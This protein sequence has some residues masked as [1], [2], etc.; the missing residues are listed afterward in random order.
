MEDSEAIPSGW[1]MLTTMMLEFDSGDSVST[2]FEQSNEQTAADALAENV[3]LKN[4]DLDLECNA[5][6]AVE[7]AEVV[8]ANVAVATAHDG[9]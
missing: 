9:Q 5:V 4:V 1:F 8:R 7:E 6:Q 2:G 3:S